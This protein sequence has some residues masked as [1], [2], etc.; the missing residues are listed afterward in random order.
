MRFH[1][2]QRGP[3]EPRLAAEDTGRRGRGKG[4][5][6]GGPGGSCRR[7]A[8]H[9]TQRRWRR[10]GQGEESE[11]RGRADEDRRGSCRRSASHRTQRRWR[12]EGLSTGSRAVT[13][14]EEPGG[15]GEEEPGGNGEGGAG[16]QQRGGPGA[17]GGEGWRWGYLRQK[18]GVRRRRTVKISR[19]PMS[20]MSERVH[21]TP[22]GTRA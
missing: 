14:R 17:T 12:R 3:A 1:S 6:R 19:R 11:A 16:R 18:E 21:L 22:A 10:A 4:P 13:E 7:S 2:T 8:S 5:R 20:M 15:N 9:R